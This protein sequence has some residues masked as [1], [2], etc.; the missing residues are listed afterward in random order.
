ME[1]LLLQIATDTANNAANN[2][3]LADESL[4]LLGLLIKGGWIML[5]I[6]LMA[7]GA[8]YIFIERYMTIRKAAEIDREFMDKVK[9]MVANENIEGARS[10]CQNHNSPVARMLDKG[11]ARI[12]RPFNDI[13]VAIENVGNLEV[14][15]LEKNLATLATI[16]GAAPMLGFLGTV[17][18]MIQAFFNLAQA[19]ENVSPALL[20]GGIYQALVTTAFGLAVGIIAY[21]GYNYL[22]SMVEKVIFRMEANTVEFMDLLQEP[23]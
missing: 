14:F 3:E 21:I 11:I 4:S 1:H 19:G 15:K 23:V 8:V 17:A 6:L 9:D 22:T 2:N 13:K 5:P 10:I 18:G 12:G 7:I 16:S 20:A